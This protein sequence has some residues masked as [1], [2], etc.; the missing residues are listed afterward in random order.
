MQFHPARLRRRAPASDP[1]RDGEDVGRDPAA[2]GVGLACEAARSDPRLASP[3][4]ACSNSAL[5]ESLRAF[6]WRFLAPPCPLTQRF[7]HHHREPP[8]D[9]R[10]GP[11]PRRSRLRSR[12]VSSAP[13]RRGGVVRSEEGPPRFARRARR[14]H[15][16]RRTR[17]PPLSPFHHRAQLAV[18]EPGPELDPGRRAVAIDQKARPRP[19]LPHDVRR[20][21]GPVGASLRRRAPPAL[22][23]RL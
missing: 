21:Q 8:G 7:R 18:L 19:N 15:R 12:A 4:G 2:V 6:Q 17:L 10:G 23:C 20:R 22:G 1:W 16:P 11:A 3:R 5:G 9:R 14:C 13:G